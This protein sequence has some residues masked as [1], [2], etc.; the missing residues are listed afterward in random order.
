MTGGYIEHASWWGRPLGYLVRQRCCGRANK[1][2]HGFG[3]FDPNRMIG[4]EMGEADR[5]ALRTKEAGSSRNSVV[6]SSEHRKWRTLPI[7]AGDVV[8]RNV[9]VDGVRA[10][11][12]SVFE[13][14][15]WTV[16]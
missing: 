5:S 7:Q 4:S 13:R 3:E 1:R 11:P 12:L 2:D 8:V 16:R 14:K 15:P 6:I 10:Y 9:C